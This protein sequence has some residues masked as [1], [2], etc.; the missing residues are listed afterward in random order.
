VGGEIEDTRGSGAPK[1]LVIEAPWLVNGGHGASLRHHKEDTGAPSGAPRRR[2]HTVGQGRGGVVSVREGGGA[3]NAGDG[4]AADLLPH[5][6]DLH[7]R[8][9]QSLLRVGEPA[10]QLLLARRRLLRLL[11][12]HVVDEGVHEAH[13]GRAAWL[14]LVRAP[15][16]GV[17]DEAVRAQAP[18]VSAA[19]RLVGRFSFFSAFLSLHFVSELSA[20]KSSS[21][22]SKLRRSTSV[23]LGVC[24]G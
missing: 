10:P 19:D 12:R 15:R 21:L 9:R 2:H 14:L 11:Q 22:S 8:V 16:V 18:S 6:V 3:A 7:P 24:D 17:A 4:L 1:R 20:D 5:P 13:A 23:S